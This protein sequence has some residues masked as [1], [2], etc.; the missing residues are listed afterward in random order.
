MSIKEA[1][2]Q[3]RSEIRKAALA[4]GR[5]PDQIRLIAV[6]KTVSADRIRQGIAAG[7]DTLG[8]NYI[9]EALPKIDALA[10]QPVSWH[11]IGRLQTKKAAYAVRHFDLIHSVD[12]FK[13]AAEIDKQAQK[14]GKIQQIL[15]QVN[16]AEEPSKAGVAKDDA[17][18]LITDISR[19]EH[20]SIRGLMTMPP[21]FDCPE[22]ARPYF[23]SLSR[24]S[25]HIGSSGIENVRMEALSMGMTGDFAAAIAE[26]ATMVRIGT[27]I[28]GERA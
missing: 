5:D 2:I 25:A 12:R 13:L 10:D 4:S 14:M 21:F 27:A 26:G 3:I 23:K 17:L 16:I 24:L 22:K 1:V 9:Q 28:F 11:F 7:I 19:L 8:E 15:I 6:T 20:L 18:A